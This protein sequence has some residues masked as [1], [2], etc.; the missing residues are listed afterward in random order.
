M[1]SVIWP[2]GAQLGK[3]PALSGDLGVICMGYPKTHM[4]HME[5]WTKEA[6]SIISCFVVEKKTI[7]CINQG[8]LYIQFGFPE[9]ESSHYLKFPG[10]HQEPISSVFCG[11]HMRGVLRK[12]GSAIF[13]GSFPWS[14][15]FIGNFIWNGKDTHRHLSYETSKLWY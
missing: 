3:W 12:P 14:Q 11:L 10:G 4:E 6:K 2:G 9:H 1:D 13:I 5:K 7:C 8:W 15:Y